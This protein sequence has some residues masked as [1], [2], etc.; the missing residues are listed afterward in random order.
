MYQ[1]FIRYKTITTNIDICLRRR[2]HTRSDG[3]GLCSRHRVEKFYKTLS[4]HSI[5][6]QLIFAKRTTLSKAPHGI[7]LLC[8]PRKLCIHKLYI[9]EMKIIECLDRE[10]KAEKETGNRQAFEQIRWINS[11]SQMNL[12]V[13]SYTETNM[14]TDR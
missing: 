1:A 14:Y 8:L 12:N 10:T 3:S 11:Y 4:V 7:S 9:R 13:G 6:L 2:W 5:E